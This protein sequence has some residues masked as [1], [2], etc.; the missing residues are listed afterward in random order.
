MS[1]AI[2]WFFFRLRLISAAP[3][4]RIKIAPSIPIVLIYSKW[5]WYWNWMAHPIILHHCTLFI[6]GQWKSHMFRHFSHAMVISHG[7]RCLFKAL[8]PRHC[9]GT[10]EFNPAVASCMG[11]SNFWRLSLEPIGLLRGS[12][13]YL[14]N[15]LVNIW[16]I[17]GKY[18]VKIWIIYGKY[19]VKIWII[20]G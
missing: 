16:I 9:R 20:Y 7:H 12:L 11:M 4:I 8:S 1:C 13:H 15:P 3:K 17:Y 14:S 18:M 2:S 19:M 6:A 5:L 10:M